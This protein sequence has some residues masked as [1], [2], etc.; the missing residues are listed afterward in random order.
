MRDPSVSPPSPPLPDDPAALKAMLIELSGRNA[1][2]EA[3]AAKL[4]AERQRLAQ[5]NILLA[6]ELFRYKKW[7]YGPRADRLADEN[8]L[9]QMLL[10]FTGRFK[11]AV[12]AEA[13][14]GPANVD[15]AGEAKQSR[16]AGGGGGRRHLGAMDELTT[17]T[18]EHDIPES[19]KV[20][21]CGCMKE[22]I[23]EE[24]SVQLEYVPAH[25]EKHRHR[26]FKY[27]CRVC[28]AKGK[29][30]RIQVADKPRQPI[31]KS[32][33]GPGL[34]GYIVTSKYADYLPLYR[35]EDIFARLGVPIARSTLSLWLGA[36]AGLVKPLYN[37]M[38]DRV[39]RSKVLGTDDTVMPMQR[40]GGA[41]R[42]RIWV[43]V[44]DEDHPYNVFD[45]TQSRSRDGPM[46]FLTGYRGTIIADAYGGYDGIVVGNGADPS[47]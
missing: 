19:E 37:L 29:D 20:C 44:G 17:T 28:G 35:I 33:A 46:K 21:S 10:E 36:V 41:K 14:A 18:H 4:E 38:T 47:A 43:Y 16:K 30:P 39:R 31:E 32:M 22:R 7:F 26:R 9:A 24:E 27:A 5:Q 8:G 12:A 1:Q 2:L 15:E 6:H 23:G 45:F 42:C 40:V 25:F 3:N 34:L 13:A 11:Q